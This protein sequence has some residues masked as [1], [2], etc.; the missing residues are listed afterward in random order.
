VRLAHDLGVDRD[1]RW[2]GE[3]DDLDV[4]FAAADASVSASLSEGFPNV[5]GEAMASG[6]PCIGTDV[7]ATA[8]IIGDPTW[9]VPPGDPAAL[10]A[11]IS[12]MA[13]LGAAERA[14]LGRQARERV[15]AEFS[16]E[17]LGARLESLIVPAGAA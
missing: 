5:L 16:V 14:E 8:A 6:V 2:L 3:R 10:A 13:A 7:G 15:V 1:V 12:A 9:V 17:A 4:V 11:A